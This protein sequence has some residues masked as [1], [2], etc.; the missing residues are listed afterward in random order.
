MDVFIGSCLLIQSSGSSSGI[1]SFSS[2]NTSDL[3]TATQQVTKIIHKVHVS[4]SHARSVLE[5]SVDEAQN[6]SKRAGE[7]PT[8]NGLY[9]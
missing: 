1:F 9:T 2:K 7:N 3:S 8:D 5:T 4:T 6:I